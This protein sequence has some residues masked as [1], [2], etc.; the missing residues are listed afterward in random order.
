MALTPTMFSVTRR[1]S[2][3]RI[4]ASP[5]NVQL[6]NDAH[7]EVSP[8]PTEVSHTSLLFSTYAWNPQLTDAVAALYHRALP[9]WTVGHLRA[10]TLKLR[11]S[12]IAK[13]T[14]EA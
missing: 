9:K 11:E 14:D 8:Q 4:T 2:S 10:N 7:G 3:R 1:G 6:N 12:Y 5:V 13:P